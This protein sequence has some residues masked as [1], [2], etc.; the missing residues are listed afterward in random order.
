MVRDVSGEIEALRMEMGCRCG[1]GKNLTESSFASK[2]FIAQ[3]RYGRPF[4]ISW[5]Y[6]CSEVNRRIGGEEFSAS[7]LG[8]HVDIDYGLPMELYGI[9]QGLIAAEF[10]H[11]RIYTLSSAVDYGR[12]YAHVHV[13]GCVSRGGPYLETRDYDFGARGVAEPKSYGGVCGRGDRRGRS[14]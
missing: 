6:R 13:D 12:K 11:I 10:E 4:K 9:V 1:C 14:G 2:L 8:E 5:G 3:G 7:L